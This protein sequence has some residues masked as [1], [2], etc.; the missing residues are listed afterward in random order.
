MFQ[1]LGKCDSCLIFQEFKKY[2]FK[3]DVKP[4]TIQK[5]MSLTII[6]LKKTEI[7]PGLSLVFIDSVHYLNNSLDNLV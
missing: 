2:N 4:K 7:E 6:K 1:S 5:Y 3:I